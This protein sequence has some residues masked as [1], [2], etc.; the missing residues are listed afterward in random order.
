MAEPAPATQ[1]TMTLGPQGL[2]AGGG[3]PTAATRTL[4]ADLL[5]D[6]AAAASP[7][8]AGQPPATHLTV[9]MPAAAAGPER[10]PPTDFLGYRLVRRIGAGGMGLVYEAYQE[11]LRRQVALK[12]LKPEV[13]DRRSFSERFLRECKAMA[14]VNH[15]AVVSIYDAGEHDGFLYMALEYVPGG[16][17]ARL[18]QR[19]GTI[20]PRTALG[21]LI[22]CTHGLMAIDA[23]GLVHRDIK[24]QNIF[25]DRDLQPKIGDLGLARAADGEDRMTITGSAWG[26]PAYMSPEQV[27][28]IGDIDIRSDLYALGATL[29]TILTGSEPFSGA[30]SYLVTHQVL[31]EP[32]PDPRLRD[33]T[34]PAAVAAIVLKAMAKERAERFQTPE[35]LLQ[36]LQRAQEGKTLLHAALTPHPGGAGAAAAAL[37][38]LAAVSATAHT[39]TLPV[40]GQ[41]LGAASAVPAA[42]LPSLPQQ[43]PSRAAGWETPSVAPGLLMGVALLTVAVLLY[44]VVHSMEGQTEIPRPAAAGP[45]T[46]MP[47]TAEAPSW[48]AASGADSHGRWADLVVG[49]VIQRFRWIPPG[50]FAM[51]SPEDE[52]GRERS[53]TRHQVA[54]TKGFWMS[55]TPC[56]VALWSAMGGGGAGAGAG[57]GSD[58]DDHAASASA[59]LPQTDISFEDCQ[60]QLRRLGA[61]C[62]PLV[63]RLPTEAEW[64]YACR[65]GTS[66]AFPGGPGIAGCGWSASGSVLAAWRAHA[67][68]SGAELAVE[69]DIGQLRSDPALGSHPVGQ[70]A[71]NP[72]GL[73]D[74]NGNALQWCADA[75]DGLEALPTGDESDPIGRDGG[76]RVCRGGSWWVP[77]ERCRSAARSAIAPDERH[78]WLGLRIVIGLPGPAGS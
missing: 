7:G 13:A 25:L 14:A 62:A 71:A 31:T 26:T 38:A 37:A 48:A 35:Q 46:A 33:A 63:A 58:G 65:A 22:G 21:L 16:D 39:G 20:D 34:I 55:A 29:Y 28:G 11:R 73:Y 44:G 43:R 24:P 56:T 5:A 17:L 45:A 59:S 53:E 57:S 41:G 47:T 19:R 61:H 75:W 70:L 72:W 42:P 77:E 32:A 67:G 4:G 1:R 18:V 27:R 68:E 8:A 3:Q 15:P 69:T 36:D 74:M 66:T 49:P 54:I 40:A 2:P 60:R 9:A 50:S 51:G 23:A 52:P 6:A 76:R 64:E 10:L 30:T 12:L 78:P